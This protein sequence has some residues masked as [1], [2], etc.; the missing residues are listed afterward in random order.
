MRR[1]N[2]VAALAGAV[3]AS[4]LVGVA[5]PRMPKIGVL[6]LGGLEPFSRMFREG[7]RDLGYSEGRNIE[8]E[9]RSAQG[10]AALL[11]Q[12]AAELLRLRVDIIVASETPSV[13]A[14]RQATREIPIV[15]AAAGDP[16][17]TGLIVSLARPGGNITGLSAQAAELAGKSLELIREVLPSAS[18]VAVMALVGNPLTKPFLEQAQIAART[19][20]IALKSIVVRGAGEFDAVFTQMADE[21]IEAVLVQPS[22]P[23]KPAADLALKHR[24]PAVSITSAFAA[25]GGLLSYAASLSERYR[26]AAVYVDKILKGQKPAD[27]PVGQPTK[28]ELVINMRTAKALGLTMPTALLARADEVIE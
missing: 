2:F 1:R 6:L 4:P 26:G 21:R 16:V 19:L 13:Q 5:Q 25:A 9:F 11:P 22:L 10:N 23:H 15:M 7:L 3:V 14:A 8:I 24:L 12:L 17:G 28:F 18:R 27:L 20:G